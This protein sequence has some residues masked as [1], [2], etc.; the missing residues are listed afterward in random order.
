MTSAAETIQHIDQNADTRAAI[1]YIAKHSEITFRISE[2]VGKL[3]SSNAYRFRRTSRQPRAP[4]A[5]RIFRQGG[6]ARLVF[7][8]HQRSVADDGD[9][10]AA[11]A[12]LQLVLGLSGHDG[13]W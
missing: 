8:S 2:K 11:R 7:D 12:Q 3:T 1:A 5:R 9:I 10:R 4:Q 6:G 13:S